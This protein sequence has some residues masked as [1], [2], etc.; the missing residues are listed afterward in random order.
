[1]IVNSFPYGITDVSTLLS[2]SSSDIMSM[3]KVLEQLEMIKRMNEVRQMH[4]YKIYY[5]EKSGWMTTVD[6]P[7]APKSKKKIHRCSEASL[8]DALAKWYLDNPYGKNT[9]I[10][11]LYQEWIT[12]KETPYNIENIKRIRYEWRSYYENEPMS[13]KI[14][15]TPIAKLTSLDLKIWAENLLRKHP[16]DKKK[17]ARIFEIVNQLLEY[18]SDEDINIIQKNPWLNAKKK[19]NRA[20]I[21]R[22]VMPENSTQVFSDE[23]RRTIT[24]MVYEDLVKYKS[25]PTSAGLQLLFLL[26]TGLRVGECCGLKWSDVKDGYL[27]IRRQADNNRVKGWTKSFAGWRD[28]PLTKRSLEIL[29]DVKEFNQERGFD[30]EWIFQSANAKYDYRIS[31]NAA[32]RKLRKLC[33]RMNSEIRSP[34]KCRKTCISTLLDSPYVNDKFVQQFAGHS[35]FTTTQKYYNF[36]RKNKQEQAAALDKALALPELG[37]H[38]HPYQIVPS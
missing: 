5:S 15:D 33:T 8:W 31:Y 24:Q 9:T 25:T 12:N 27:S 3:D 7:T 6:D 10:R 14:I 23:E 2:S 20:L 4:P 26:E 38:N 16:S 29:E 17:F 30:K 1:M 18:A 28:I 22:P 37:Q 11:I 13:E 19:I 32:D 21:I 35:D 34:H 36:D